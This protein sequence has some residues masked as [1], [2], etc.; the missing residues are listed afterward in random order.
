M[1]TLL[2]WRADAA[3]V[4]PGL[5]DAVRRALPPH[6]ASREDPTEEATSTSMWLDSLAEQ[7]EHDP[8]ALHVSAVDRPTGTCAAFLSEKKL[9]AIRRPERRHADAHDE[10]ATLRELVVSLA[11][12]DAQEAAS[13]AVVT[14]DGR[15]RP[16]VVLVVEALPPAARRLP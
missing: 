4:T 5:C 3:C 10:C 12:G 8:D 14:D 9:Q 7:Y 2:A 6:F 11:G 13:A 1:A 16:V 15:G